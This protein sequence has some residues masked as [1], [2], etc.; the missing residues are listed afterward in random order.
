[1][2]KARCKSVDQYIAS[3]SKGAQGVLRLL[4]SAIRKAVPGADEMISYDMPT[5]KLEGGRL[6][7][8]AV[9]KQHYSIYAATDSVVATFQHE[10]APY[11]VIKGTIRFPLCEPVP[12]KLIERLAKFRAREVSARE[13][14]KPAAAKKR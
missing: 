13:K 10:L 3:Q 5:Y 11:Q 12:V 1:M 4:P 9:W 6:L 8:F 14:V 2:T 7:Y